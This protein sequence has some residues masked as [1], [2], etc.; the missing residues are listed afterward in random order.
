MPKKP[1]APE[2][3]KVIETFGNPMWAMT[4]VGGSEPSCWNGD[5][6]VLKY[7]ITVELIEEPVEVIRA[8]L[9]DLWDRCD[10]HHHAAP[11][12]SAANRY[13]V[14]LVGQY[15]TKRKLGGA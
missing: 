8:R 15:G 7:R 1:K 6:S 11:L 9:Q 5:V 4:R 12:Q 13:G 10:N 2:F 3:P 14:E